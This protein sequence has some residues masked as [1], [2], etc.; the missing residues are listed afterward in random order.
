MRLRND[1]LPDDAPPGLAVYQLTEEALPSCHVYMEAQVFTPD[2]KL[3]LLHRSATPHGGDKDDAEHRYLL[4][5]LD[6]KAVL[7]PFTEETG[8]TAPSITP[9][10]RECY[11]FVDETVVNG[12]RLT[13]KRV[14]IDSS[15]RE[16]VLVV[17]SFLPDTHYRPSRLY[18]LSTISAD[19]RRLALSAFLGDGTPGKATWGLMVFDLKDATVELVLEGPTWCNL[20]AQYCRSLDR[21]HDIMVQENHGNEHAPDGTVTKLVSGA[22]AD[23]H[24]IRDDGT[25]MRSFPWGRDG[26]EFCQGHQC[27][28]GTGTKAITSTSVSGPPVC[29]LIESPATAFAG[30]VG[31]ATPGGERN[32]L[33]RGFA[34]PRFHHFATDR[35]GRRFVSD[36]ATL[37]G[38]WLLYMADFGPGEGGALE[39]WRLVLDTRSSRKA[40]PHPFLSPDGTRAFFNSDESGVLQAYMLVGF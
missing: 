35:Q 7:S 3:L 17:D 34:N 4:C 31:L 9:D 23:I 8:A 24:L 1:L 15:M 13:L 27:W 2:S 5:A 26:R 25:D 40:H 16:T 22:G 29:E 10:G 18:P 12:G 33:S 38:R 32:D 37:D 28:R 36:A 11:Y 20:H 39:D 19:G 30:H 14:S 21:V 6:Y